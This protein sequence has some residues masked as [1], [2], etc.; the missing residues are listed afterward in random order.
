VTDAD[1]NAVSCQAFKD[2]EGKNPGSAVFTFKK[3]A[4]IA[5]NPVQ[6]GSISCSLTDGDNADDSTT[7]TTLLTAGPTGT[8][9]PTQ[10][11]GNS[12]VGPTGTPTQPSSP[13]GSSTDA[14]ENPNNAG[15]MGLSIGALAVG[16][17]ALVL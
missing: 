14:P 15:R 16:V 8:G 9:S 13:S 1:I 17:A 7:I 11:G 6:E 3:P 12:T 2:A 4:L 10:S 5:T